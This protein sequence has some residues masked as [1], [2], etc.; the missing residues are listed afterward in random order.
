MTLNK[1]KKGIISLILLCVFLIEA[2][3]SALVLAQGE[4]ASTPASES[5]DEIQ[6]KIKEQKTAMDELQK[7]I[8]AYEKQID[9]RRQQALS[10]KNEICLIEDQIS[11]TKLQLELKR[12]E[13]TSLNLKIAETEKRIEEKQKEMDSQKDRMGEFIRLLYQSD[14]KTNVEIMLARDGLTEFFDQQQYLQTIE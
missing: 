4:D 8:D 3:K 14:Q 6:Q 1:N 5:V 13:T 10:I 11:E 2:S 7:K 12:R 9:S